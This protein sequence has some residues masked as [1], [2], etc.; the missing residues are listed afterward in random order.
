VCNYFGTT[1]A[2]NISRSANSRTSATDEK[3]EEAVTC[4][5][6]YAAMPQNFII[7]A[8]EDVVLAAAVV[9]GVLPNGDLERLILYNPKMLMLVERNTNTT[10]GPYSILAHEI[11]HHLLWHTLQGDRSRSQSH[12][13]ELAAD[14][15]SGNILAQM[16]ADLD[17]ALAVMKLL[18]DDSDSE[19][20]PP[21]SARLVAITDGWREG[22]RLLYL[23]GNS[24]GNAKIEELKAEQARH[25]AIHTQRERLGGADFT[26]L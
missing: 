8:D 22:Q 9:G 16:G 11:G 1:V 14:K 17:D 12:A 3:V 13:D 21:R 24:K 20:H 19:T 18:D 5:L 25:A 10:F 6:L 26:Y 15:Y 4:I 2:G 7:R 23:R